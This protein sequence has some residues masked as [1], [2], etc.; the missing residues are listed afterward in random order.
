MIC[1]IGYALS[2]L[3][4][5]PYYVLFCIG[6]ILGFGCGVLNVC[7]MW[8]SWA[9]FDNTNATIAGIVL[10]GYTI[11]PG[12]FG[13]IFTQIVNPHNLSPE[14][15]D[16]S[17]DLIFPDS[18]SERVPFALLVFAGLIVVSAFIAVLMIFLRQEAQN[19][20]DIFHENWR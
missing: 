8:P 4:Y 15:S 19:Y 12:L 5:N 3:W 20:D 9:H 7:S 16:K 2:A 11:S 6:I 10:M 13:F 17:T 14:K 18:V 1:G